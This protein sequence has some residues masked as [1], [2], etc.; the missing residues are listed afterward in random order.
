MFFLEQLPPGVT[1]GLAQHRRVP[2]LVYEID[3][4]VVEVKLVTHQVYHQSQQFVGGGALTGS[5]GDAP[6][7]LQLPGALG[8]VLG[9]L[10]QRADRLAQA[11]GHDAK[12]IGEHA[13]LVTARRVS[14]GHGQIAAG[15]RHR[16]LRQSGDRFDQPPGD[17]RADPGGDDSRHAQEYQA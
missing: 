16:A 11:G 9:R 3:L 5:K 17:Q 14:H 12:G 4:D 10:A 13:D 6:A 1:G 15:N 7:G 2:F 8:Q